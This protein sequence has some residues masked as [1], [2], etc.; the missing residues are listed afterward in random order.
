MWRRTSVQ[1]QGPD[2][3]VCEESWNYQK[4]PDQ[5]HMPQ[6]SFD[7][8]NFMRSCNAETGLYKSLPP[9]LVIHLYHPTYLSKIPGRARYAVESQ[10]PKTDTMGNM[11]E[12]LE[13]PKK[14]RRLQYYAT[15]TT[16]KRVYK[17]LPP[18]LSLYYLHNPT[19]LSKRRTVTF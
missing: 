15:R 6:E 8:C 2:S 3:P 12:K 16:E 9:S 18:S 17:P 14:N 5:R 1:I 11:C 4:K 19:F 10:C 7:F 13:P